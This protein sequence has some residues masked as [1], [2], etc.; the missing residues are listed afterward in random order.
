MTKRIIYTKDRKY[1]YI[2]EL[3]CP[4]CS[5]F[6]TETFEEEPPYV[7]GWE[8][9]Y[10]YDDKYFRLAKPFTTRKMGMTIEYIREDI[11]DDNILVKDYVQCD[12]HGDIAS[13]TAHCYEE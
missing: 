2:A 8:T 4:F 5:W 9:V 6:S 7:K 13:C 1:Y 10:K 12:R 3:T 11:D